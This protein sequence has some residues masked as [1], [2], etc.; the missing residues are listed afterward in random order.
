[1]S[2]AEP[3]AVSPP[4]LRPQIVDAAADAAFHASARQ[5]GLDPNDYWV[6]R[7]VEY[8]WDVG[9]LYIETFCGRTQGL[10]VLEF[11]C[12]LGATAIVLSRLGAQVSA[13]DVGPRV[14]E[15]ARLNAQRY[16]AENIEFKLL[17]QGEKLPYD[18]GFDL[19]TCNSVLEY[20]QP[21]ELPGVLQELDRVLRP[22]GLLLVLGTS[23]RLSPREVHSRRWLSNY[24]P[25]PVDRLLGHRQRGIFPWAVRKNLRFY[26]DLV[27]A[28]RGAKYFELRKRLGDSPAKLAVL[29]V[30]AKLG[31]LFGLSVGEVT[32]SF[33][34]VLRKPD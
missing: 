6:G 34:Q 24:I 3:P 12:N 9:R 30:L 11:G 26:R 1:M 20:I 21:E 22:G 15:L 13:A 27:A 7:Y 10:R 31:G 17:T 25:R 18:G 4:P 19:V 14:V 28:D 8:E 16:R 33:L 2:I 32:P 29:H 5:L 23:N